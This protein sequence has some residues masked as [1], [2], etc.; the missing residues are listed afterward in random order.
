MKDSLNE[1]RVYFEYGV[2]EFNIPSFDPFY[3]KEV[4]Q[5]RGGSA[6]NYKLTLRNI[7]ESGWTNSYIYSFKSDLKHGIIKYHQWFPA[8]FLRGDWEFDSIF[9]LYEN[10]GT[11]NLSLCK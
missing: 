7:F 10:Q 4:V 5:K 6:L 9:G 8:K 3:A 11:F 1:L 2:P